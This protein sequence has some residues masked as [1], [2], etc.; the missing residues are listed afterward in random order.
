MTH[1]L[2]IIC[3]CPECK[4]EMLAIDADI[5]EEAGCLLC[6][7]CGSVVEILPDNHEIDKGT[8]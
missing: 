6:R 3:K 5:D 2:D 1:I 7:Y 8:D 4:D